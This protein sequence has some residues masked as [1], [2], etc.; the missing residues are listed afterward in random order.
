MYCGLWY[1]ILDTIKNSFCN[2]HAAL[3]YPSLLALI[4]AAALVLSIPAIYS[5]FSPLR[6][7]FG[8][9]DNRLSA[10]LV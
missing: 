4:A 10:Q 9:N 1:N 6:F 2:R 7:V 3:T 8:K 5:Q